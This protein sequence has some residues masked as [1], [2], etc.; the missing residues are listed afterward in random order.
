M[1]RVLDGE[2]LLEAFMKEHGIKSKDLARALM[3]IESHRPL[4][5]GK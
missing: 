4:K 5:E 2:A 1:K 3:V